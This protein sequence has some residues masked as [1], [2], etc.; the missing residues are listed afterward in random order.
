[1]LSPTD[2][3][4]KPIAREKTAMQASFACLRRIRSEN[5]MLGS[6]II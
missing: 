3:A 4:A 5:R 1:V 6:C 2:A